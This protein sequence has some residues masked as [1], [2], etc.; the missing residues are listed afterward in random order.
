MHCTGQSFKLSWH[1][2]WLYKA[3]KL[4]SVCVWVLVG[5]FVLIALDSSGF[6]PRV[7]PEEQPRALKI[8]LH[9]YTHIYYYYIHWG[10]QGF[11]SEV[12]L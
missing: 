1:N 3:A 8:P 4:L 9:T 10:L 11:V 6:R 12:L 5:W 2:C 7:L